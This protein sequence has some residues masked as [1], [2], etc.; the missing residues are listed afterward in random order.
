[1]AR[2]NGRSGR[3]SA[4][5]PAEPPEPPQPVPARANV[6]TS[7]TP[8]SFS[9]LQPEDRARRRRVVVAGLGD[10]ERALQG[11]DRGPARAGAQRRRVAGL[12]R[13]GA[14]GRRERYAAERARRDGARDQQTARPCPPAAAADGRGAPAPGALERLTPALFV[15]NLAAVGR[16]LPCLSFL[17]LRGELTGSRERVRYAA[18]R[19]RFA[20]ARALARAVGSPVPHVE[21]TADS[22][23]FQVRPREALPRSRFT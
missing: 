19:R 14:P 13:L 8:R 23:G 21:A 9:V 10:A 4:A 16:H 3:G 15:C 18:L 22:A 7:A 20:P 2:K 5:A 1:V 12:V 11:G 17:R 6:M